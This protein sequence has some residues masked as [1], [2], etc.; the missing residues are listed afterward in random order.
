MVDKLGFLDTVKKRLRPQ[1]TEAVVEAGEHMILWAKI[2]V[3]H[4]IKLIAAL[5]GVEPEIIRVVSFMERWVWIASFVVFF[6]R[7]LGRLW[8]MPRA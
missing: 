3:V 6:W 4:F 1:A 5:A 2:L 7:V 8:R